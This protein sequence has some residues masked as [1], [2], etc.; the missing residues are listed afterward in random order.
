[1]IRHRGASVLGILCLAL[2][3][4]FSGLFA[5]RVGSLYYDHFVI[6]GMVTDLKTREDQVSE[7]TEREIKR[8]LSTRLRINGLDSAVGIEQFQLDRNGGQW[9]LDLSYERRVNFI[10]P[11]DLIVSFQVSQQIGQP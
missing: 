11:I 2:L 10:E 9:L 8:D 6:Q 1:M 7:Q 4:S 5:L 3:L